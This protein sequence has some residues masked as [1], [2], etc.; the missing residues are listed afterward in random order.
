MIV[1]LVLFH[2]FKIFKFFVIAEYSCKYWRGIWYCLFF[3]LDVFFEK[4]SICVL[5]VFLD[6][7]VSCPGK[8][9]AEFGS[10]T[11]L[12]NNSNPDTFKPQPIGVQ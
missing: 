12:I 5:G 2:L 4:L 8:H 3:V 11:G 1:F 9:I 7:Y 6:L 10:E